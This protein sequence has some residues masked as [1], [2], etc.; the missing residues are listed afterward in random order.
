MDQLLEL[1]NSEN[2]DNILDVDLQMFQA[3]LVVATSSKFYT[4]FTVLFHK[5]GGANVSITNFMSH[6]SMLV[7]TKANVKLA[8]GN[9][10]HEQV[11]G[12]ISCCFTNCYVIYPVVPVYYFSFHPSKTIS[13]G[14]LKFM[15]VLKRVHTNLLNIVICWPS[16]FFLD[17]TLSD[18]RLFRLY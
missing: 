2:A 12:I 13:L 1:L 10:G 4:D 7:L 9:T 3:W 8:N 14:A 11:I 15:L 5:Y 17:I 18:S 16:I 6:F